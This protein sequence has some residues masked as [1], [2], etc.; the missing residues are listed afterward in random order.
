MVEI[1]E[2]SG[3][4]NF[5]SFPA[6]H[7]GDVRFSLDDERLEIRSPNRYGANALLFT[8]EETQNLKRWFGAMLWGTLGT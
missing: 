6:D 4:G 5:I 1:R 3:D 2:A 8:V 7:G